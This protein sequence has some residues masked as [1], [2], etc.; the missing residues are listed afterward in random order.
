MSDQLRHSQH[1]LIARAVRDWFRLPSEGM[2]YRAVA[3][4]YGTYWNTGFVYPGPA[5]VTDQDG[6]LADLQ[7]Y[8]GLEESV[9]ALDNPQLEEQLGPTLIAAGW[10][11]GESDIFLAH[12]GPVN[13]PKAKTKL[14]LEP[15]TGANL[16]DY[17]LMCL[18]SFDEVETTSDEEKLL[19]EMARRRE[20]LA[21]DGRALLARV[22]GVPAGIM[23]WFDDPLDIWINGLAIR[24][25]FRGQ[26]IGSA[27]VRQ[28]LA[29]VY[30]AGRRSLLINVALS[31]SGARRLYRRLGFHDEV[32][33]RRM[34][35]PPRITEEQ[36]ERGLI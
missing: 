19:A 5:A 10:T 14:A 36:I 30:A 34:F 27:L 23:R 31:N 15:V 25:A 9:V 8:N 26:G 4:P 13:A 21:G 16:G 32:Y 33:R 3:R 17:A 35:S 28:C 2:G 22:D 1:E 7:A 6:F 20:E 29:D 12:V 24:P 11:E 18:A